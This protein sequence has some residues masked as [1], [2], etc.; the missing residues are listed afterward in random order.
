MRPRVRAAFN[1]FAKV[2]DRA[3][4]ECTETERR[5][6]AGE[7]VS[8]AEKAQYAQWLSEGAKPWRQK[9]KVMRRIKRAAR[10]AVRNAGGG[11]R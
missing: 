3:D 10:K 9:P 11:N 7:T 1:E 6:I 4:Q 2:A 8:I 5:I